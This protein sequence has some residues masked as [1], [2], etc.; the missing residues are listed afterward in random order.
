MAPTTGFPFCAHRKTSTMDEVKP[1]LAAPT[2]Q[3][4]P[5]AE[6]HQAVLAPW[7]VVHRPH[8]GFSWSTTIPTSS[9]RWNVVCDCPVSRCPPPSTA[10]KHCAAP[11]RPARTRSCDRRQRA[12]CRRRLRDFRRRLRHAFQIGRRRRDCRLL[13]A[14]RL[15]GNLKSRPHRSRQRR[16]RVFLPMP[17]IP[18]PSARPASHRHPSPSDLRAQ[19]ML[20]HPSPSLRSQAAR[21]SQSRRHQQ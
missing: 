5:E 11:P 8:L 7:K 10:P 16:R 21:S 1:I 3:H 9:H 18:Y 2:A 15:G 17:S 19:S 13:C 20:Q 14:D 4:P 12:F 6:V